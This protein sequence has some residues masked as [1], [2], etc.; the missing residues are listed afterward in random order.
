[1]S[2]WDVEEPRFALAQGPKWLRI[3]EG[4]GLLAGIPD[5]P[6]EAQVV[7]TATIEREVRRLDE[8]R[9]SWGQEEVVAVTTEKVGSATQQF[10]IDV[11]E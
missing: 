2:F 10:V 5:A 8:R 6:G 9:L 11:G 3:D 7:V 4:T 1:M